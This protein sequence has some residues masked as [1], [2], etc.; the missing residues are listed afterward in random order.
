MTINRISAAE[1]RRREGLSVA[2]SKPQIRLPKPQKM[3]KTEGEWL[4]SVQARYPHALVAY[5]P[6]TLRLP[7]GTR[8]TPDVVVID[9]V[10]GRVHEIYEVKGAH[11]HNPRS[12]HAFKEACAAF[13]FW[14]FIFAQK[15][16][17]GWTTTA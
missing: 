10:T 13:P 3:N 6:F 16:K 4:R 1:Y 2:E 15:R 12:V 5:E 14:T 17:G 9:R 8:Y 7:S 11:I